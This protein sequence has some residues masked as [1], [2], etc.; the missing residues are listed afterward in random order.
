MSWELKTLDEL[1]NIGRGRSRHRPRDAEHLYGGSYPFIQTGDV[2]HSGLYIT[3]FTQT[4]SEA[5]LAQSKL[6]QAGTLCITIAA[7]I[8]DTAI[9]GIDACFPDSIIGFTPY[10]EKAD[11]RFVKYLFDAQL[12]Q[13]LQQ[14]TQGAAQDNLSQEKLLSIKF[15]VPEIP[16]QNK[17]ADIISAYDDLIENNRRRIQLLE[18]S[19]HLLYKEWFVHLRFPCHE[20]SKVVGGIPEGWE[21][22]RLCEV[23]ETVMG[24][25]PPS[26]SYN[27]N[28]I[29]LPFHQGVTNFGSR[30]PENKTYCTIE[31]RI[32]E[33]NDILFSV[34][35]PVGRIN[36]TLDKIVIGR[37]LAAIRS[38]F[39]QQNFLFYQL[40]S[41]F[42]KE[43]MIGGGAIFAAITKKDL[44]NV[45][46]VQ[47][48]HQL[49]QMFTEYV[50]PIDRQL[51]NLYKTNKKLQ[52]ARDLL[53]PKLMSGAIGA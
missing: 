1:G 14:F 27:D 45:E 31:S 39:S 34:R 42:F 12:K 20:H 51:E 11:I 47:P 5:G 30:F 2:K 16:E 19:L 17:I 8:A 38:K 40:K 37:G 41:H 3:N 25:S 23:A 44:H 35:A 6:W 9:L 13:K 28:G 32:A 4:Y 53:L 33:P 48:T 10:P 15:L 46:L 36:I 50:T 43:D 52:Q 24:Q 7:N 26:E 49:V 21:K 22:V 29:G 18:R